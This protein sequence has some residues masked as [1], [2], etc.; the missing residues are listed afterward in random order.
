MSLEQSSL[1]TV[2][3]ISSGEEGNRLVGSLEVKAPVAVRTLVRSAQMANNLA[4]RSKNEPGIPEML[5]PA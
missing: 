1:V 4:G 2:V 3:V 5:A